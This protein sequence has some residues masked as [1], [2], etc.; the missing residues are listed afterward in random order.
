MHLWVWPMMTNDKDCLLLIDHYSQMVC[1]C[2]TQ[3]YEFALAVIIIASLYACGTVNNFCFGLWSIVRMAL[4]DVHSQPVT[5]DV[6][7][8]GYIK[9]CFICFV[10]IFLF[11]CKQMQMEK[12]INYTMFFFL[13]SVICCCCLDCSNC[14]LRC[15]RAFMYNSE[16][17][18]CF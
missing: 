1:V 11:Q 4:P 17:A 13:A 12:Y 5:F 18:D 10:Q 15:R 14:L 16:L 6:N 8:A 9:W 3:L 2:I 7:F